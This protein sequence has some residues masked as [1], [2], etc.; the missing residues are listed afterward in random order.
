MD[1][2][3]ALVQLVVADPQPVGVRELA[4]RA[5]LSPSTTSRTV[6][7][8]SDLGMV[9]KTP[10]GAVR[11]GP[12]LITLT[13]GASR[14]PATLRDRLRPLAMELAS[15]FE[16][17]AAI[18]V[19]EGDGVLYL[20][21]SRPSTAIQVVDPT[22]SSFPFHLVAPGLI[23]M[24]TWGAERL[25]AYLGEPLA[26][27]T[28]HSVTNPTKIRSRLRRAASDG[29]AWTDQ[30]L[31]LEVNGLA[32]PI[33]DRN[34]EVVA[35]ATLYGPSYRL[36]PDERPDLGGASGQLRDRAGHIDGVNPVRTG[37]RS[38]H[39]LRLVAAD[40]NM[41]SMSID[42]IQQL[43]LLATGRRQVP[44]E[45]GPNERVS[46]GAGAWI[47]WCPQ[48]LPG[49][50]DWLTHLRDGVIW[51]GA[52]RPM[53]D[54]I[55]AVPRL[56]AFSIDARTRCQTVSTSSLSE[57]RSTT[58][59]PSPPWAATGIETAR[60]RLH[61][62]PIESVVRATASSPSSASANG[63]HSCCGRL[64]AVRPGGGLSATE[65]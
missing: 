63:G 17:N 29:F 61:G 49:A 43:S 16:E 28:E 44:T 33:T 12:A 60:T 37:P 10:A 62:T 25:D 36:A 14:S 58:A 5:G 38:C 22:G 56:M 4:R 57:S 6:G 54:R 55:V 64:A 59:A 51:H 31:D 18:A 39:G 47:D 24:S 8:L 50:D 15:T 23:A 35:I 19:D 40:A 2:A 9:E 45:V 42:A 65:T 7:I 20:A 53:Y 1:R 13:R 52:E 27:A 26:A 48:W 21:G 32:T 46:L 3:F 11:P 41:C 34:G 30:E